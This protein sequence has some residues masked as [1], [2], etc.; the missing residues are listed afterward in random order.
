MGTQLFSQFPVVF[1]F[2]HSFLWYL[3]IQHLKDFRGSALITLHVPC[4][5]TQ[6]IHH[7]GDHSRG[8]EPCPE[9]STETLRMTQKRSWN[10]KRSAL[11]H[12][13]FFPLLLRFIDKTK[14]HQKKKVEYDFPM[15]LSPSYKPFNL[16]FCFF[17]LFTICLF[18]S[19]QQWESFKA[20]ICYDI[21]SFINTSVHIS[22]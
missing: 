10:S 4:L 14:E 21:I 17:H 11:F 8:G 2:F 15:Y 12:F 20:N 22:K 18:P 6:Q 19:S 9:Q 3:V 16:G 13:P 5:E 7:V 1:I